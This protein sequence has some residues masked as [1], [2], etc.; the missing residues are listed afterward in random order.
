MGLIF[1]LRDLLIAIG[2]TIFGR[3]RRR[4]EHA[5]LIQAPRELVWRMLRAR[6]IVFDGLM[7]LHVHAESLP[8]RPNLEAVHISA[9]DTQLTMLTRIADERPGLAI[10]YEILPDGTEPALIEGIDDYIG[11]VL[12]DV[13]EGTRLDLM[14]ETTPARWISRITVPLGLRSGARR[15]KRKAEAMAKAEDGLEASNG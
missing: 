7:P 10:L 4:Y 9:G 5:V 6:D 11:F 13:D 2:D 14:R 1:M 12:A 8:G 3:T 15:Y